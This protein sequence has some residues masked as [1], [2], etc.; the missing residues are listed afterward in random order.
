MKLNMNKK[1]FDKL[2]EV[3][4]MKDSDSYDDWLRQKCVDLRYAAE[5]MMTKIDNLDGDAGESPSEREEAA[6]QCYEVYC[7]VIN[8]K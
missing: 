1:T 3:P 4:V 5:Y 8:Q 6:N 2:F 7:K